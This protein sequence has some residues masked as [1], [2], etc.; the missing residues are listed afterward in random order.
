MFFFCSDIE[1]FFI[2]SEG[3]Y[4]FFIGMIYKLKVIIFN[5]F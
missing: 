4:N 3:G 5:N 2:F 1:G